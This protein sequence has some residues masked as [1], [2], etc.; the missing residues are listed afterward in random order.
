MIYFTKRFEWV[1]LHF[2]PV[3]KILSNQIYKNQAPFSNKVANSKIA[4][5]IS[6]VYYVV[7]GYKNTI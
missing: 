1:T 2:Y 5:G 3:V 4:Y 7:F 6:P